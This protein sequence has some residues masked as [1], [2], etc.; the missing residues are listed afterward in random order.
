MM[1]VTAICIIS[2][3]NNSEIEFSEVLLDGVE[4][5]PEVPIGI[6]NGS[7]FTRFERARLAYASSRFDIK[8]NGSDRTATATWLVS[9]LRRAQFLFRSVI[10]TIFE[11]YTLVRTMVVFCKLTNLWHD[12]R[13]FKGRIEGHSARVNDLT[14]YCRFCERLLI[15]IIGVKPLVNIFLNDLE[16]S[17][18]LFL[19]NFDIW[20]H[21]DPKFKLQSLLNR[22]HGSIVCR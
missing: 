16:V 3:G 6:S 2:W 13:V 14:W 21:L 5:E 17:L 7:L 9:M 20:P 18:D 10:Q 8:A 12:I 19:L 15:T 22:W 4:F 1:R 11:T